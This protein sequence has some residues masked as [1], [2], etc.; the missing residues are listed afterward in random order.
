MQVQEA[1]RNAENKSSD[2]Y[3]RKLS[4]KAAAPSTTVCRPEL[5]LTP[6]LEPEEAFYYQSQI[7]ILQWAIQRQSSFL[8]PS[9]PIPRVRSGIVY[10]T[11]L[12]YTGPRVRLVWQRL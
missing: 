3:W 12:S 6:E 4:K 10:P 7:G 9:H 1:T 8:T 2:E 11:G 5:D